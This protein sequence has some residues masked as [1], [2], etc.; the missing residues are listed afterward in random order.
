VR[1]TSPSRLRQFWE[2]R[3]SDAEIARRD[4]TAWLKIAKNS[5]W[6]NFASLKQS[7]GSADHVG[8]C[9]VF[10][11]GNNRYRLIGR[12][13]YSSQQFKGRI[14]VLRVMDHQ[15]YDK[16]TWIDACGCYE[17]PP[18]KPTGRDSP[19]TGRKARLHQR[20]NGR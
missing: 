14:Y 19:S 12:V 10:D 16:R 9:V 20:K 7:F 5:D 6:R 1:V 15:E 2:T 4:L 8:N 17:P 3:T 11:V 18:K 13:F